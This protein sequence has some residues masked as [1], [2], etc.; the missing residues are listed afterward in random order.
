MREAADPSCL[1]TDGQPYVPAYQKGGTNMNICVCA[2]QVPDTQEIR[3]DPEKHTLIRTGVASIL[4][5]FDAYALET[6]VRLKEQ[7]GGSVTVISMGPSQA[8]DMLRNCLAVGAD[9]G[10]LISGNSFGGSDTLATSYILSQAIR[11]IEAR[12]KLTFDLILCGKQAI[13]GDTAQVGPGIAEHLGLP[14]VTCALAIEEKEDRLH[15]KRECEIGYDIISV[16]LPAV[17]TVSRSASEPR[18]PTVRSRMAAK[19][20]EIPVLSEKELGTVD[21][22]RCGLSGSPTRVKTTCVPVRKKHGILL[23]GLSAM[24]AAEQLAGLLFD[25]HILQEADNAGHL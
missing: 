5:P 4:N 25:T 1:H 23:Q 22:N 17:I 16:K 18:Y 2:K 6:A 8:Q 20:R 9:A 13:D 7:S 24:E 19:K 10:Y 15:V 11:A 12:E 3:I 21:R 14:Q